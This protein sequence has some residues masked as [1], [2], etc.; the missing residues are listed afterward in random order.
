MKVSENTWEDPYLFEEE[1]EEEEEEVDGG[2]GGEGGEGGDG[3]EGGEGGDGGDGGEQVAAVLED[4]SLPE[5]LEI[6]EE[7]WKA[8]TSVFDEAGTTL[9]KDVAQ[10]LVDL[11]AS[12]LERFASEQ[13]KAHEERV[14]SWAEEAKKDKEFG[15]DKFEKNLVAA[16]QA[17]KALAT[18][19][20]REL[21]DNTGLGN[22]PEMIRLFVKLSP[23]VREDQGPGAGASGG[24]REE[25]RA[26]LLYGKTTK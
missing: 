22:H 2:E 4:L 13:A 23:L 14:A 18:P 11:E 20:L 21:L 7:D 26:E 5:N 6:S 3:G 16:E 17:V 10:K 25:S 19:E 1:E 15:G 12:R 8:V 9:T 24:G